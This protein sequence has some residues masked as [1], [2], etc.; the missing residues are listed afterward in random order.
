MPKKEVSVKSY[1]RTVQGKQVHVT[2]HTRKIE[3]TGSKDVRVTKN[4]PSRKKYWHIVLK[5]KALFDPDSYG[6]LDVGKPGGMLFLRGQLKSTGEWDTQ[7][8]LLAKSDWTFTG[9]T[10]RPKTDRAW[11][12]KES[13]ESQGLWLLSINKYI[14]HG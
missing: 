1:T 12:E 7:K 14:I 13:L 2:R 4:K 5:D 6:Y 8:L 11:K 10:M 9:N 3:A